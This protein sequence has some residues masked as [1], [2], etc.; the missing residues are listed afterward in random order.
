MRTVKQIKKKS[1]ELSKKC[2][3]GDLLFQDAFHELFYYIHTD[4]KKVEFNLDN[5]LIE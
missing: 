2:L 1:I 4:D 3:D 5:K